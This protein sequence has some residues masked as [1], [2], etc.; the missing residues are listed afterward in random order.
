MRLRMPIIA[1]LGLAACTSKPVDITAGQCWSVT[2]GD[3]VQG[4]A[5]LYI[6][7]P[8]TFHVGPR[9]GGGPKCRQYPIKFASNA[10][11]KAYGKIT[12]RQMADNPEGGPTQGIIALSGD[13]VDGGDRGNPTIQI[14]DIQLAKPVKP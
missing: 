3:K 5:I 4:T 11:G 12:D 10:I 13:V 2:A 6:A 1:I 7:S 14:T 9:V 8:F